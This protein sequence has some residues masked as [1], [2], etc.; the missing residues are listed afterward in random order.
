MAARTFLFTSTNKEIFNEISYYVSNYARQEWS[1]NSA[2]RI[3]ITDDKNDNSNNL[4]EITRFIDDDGDR[5]RY[6][7]PRTG[8]LTSLI[9][10]N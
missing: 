1:V 2:K 6:E 9:S 10:V 4:V 5:H 3:K 8:F 7:H